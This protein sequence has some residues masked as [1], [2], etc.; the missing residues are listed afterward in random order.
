MLREHICRLTPRYYLFEPLDSLP[1]L[2]S[3]ERLCDFFRPC[4]PAVPTAVHRLLEL[5]IGQFNSATVAA[6]K[7]CTQIL[8]KVEP[9]G[10]DMII[11][12]QGLGTLLRSDVPPYRATAV[13]N[14]LHIALARAPKV[15]AYTSA[16]AA[17]AGNCRGARHV[18]PDRELIKRNQELAV[19][20]ERSASRVGYTALCA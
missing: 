18:E 19:L 9:L 10:V 6:I 3:E 14:V 13:G 20:N 15:Q 11:A 2:G 7:D 8:L 1:W 12:A 16:L 4:A 17:K 5:V